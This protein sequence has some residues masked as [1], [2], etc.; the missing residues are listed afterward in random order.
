M[1]RSDIEK[2]FRSNV[3]QRW[4][5]E[6]TDAVLQTLW[7]LEEIDDVRSLLGKLAA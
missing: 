4:S 6:Q 5:K 2:K 1:A 3:G 7:A